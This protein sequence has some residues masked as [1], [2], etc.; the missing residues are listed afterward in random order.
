MIDVYIRRK[1]GQEKI[2]Y[3]HPDMEPILKTTFGVIVF[4]EQ[5]LQLASKLAGFSLGK[6]DILRKAMGKKIAE[7]MALQKKEFIEGCIANKISKKLA[8]QIFDQ[9]ETFARYGFNKSHSVGYAYLAYQTAY[10]KAHYPKEFMAALMTSEMGNTD[11]IIIL[12]EECRNMGVEILPPD[13]NKSR[14]NFTVEGNSIRFGLAA[15][16]NVGMNAVNKII[17][18]REK[19]GEFNSIFDFT[20]R[21]DISAINK[22]MIESMVMAGAFDSVGKDRGQLHASVEDAIAYGQ[23]VQIDRM[24]GQTQLFGEGE[25][26]IIRPEPRLSEDGGWSRSKILSKE[27]E[28]LG[29]YI[30]GHPME[31]YRPQLR[32]FATTNSETMDELPDGVQASLGGIITRLKINTDKRGRHMG[33]VGI[34]DF[35]GSF[36]AIVFSDPFEKYKKLL[37][38][39][40][41]LLFTGKISKREEEK[42]KL[43]VSEV[44]A[45]ESFSENSNLVLQLTISN[46]KVKRMEDIKKILDKYPGEARVVLR[47]KVKNVCMEIESPQHVTPS[48]ELMESLSE[49]ISPENL[50]LSAN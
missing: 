31:K 36:E 13:I 18:E 46:K 50:L 5:V 43:M 15:I 27:K 41:M 22:R 38:N 12:K 45:L 21:C 39:N 8:T 14:A 20:S 26:S 35:Y 40:N 49:I 17:D 25:S 10:L 33:F 34:E 48:G 11:R 4:Q 28:A 6:A 42:A 23:S 47:L 9:I 24:K 30:S 19:S 37:I 1:N 44:K 32:L 2:E 29:F 7:L 3:L 16:K